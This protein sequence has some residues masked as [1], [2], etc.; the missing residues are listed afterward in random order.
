MYNNTREALIY[1]GPPYTYTP[2]G[3]RDY[4]ITGLEALLNIYTYYTYYT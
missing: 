1:G 3:V 4:G 2:I